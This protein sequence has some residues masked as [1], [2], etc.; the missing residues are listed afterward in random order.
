MVFSSRW[1]C[2]YMCVGDLCPFSCYEFKIVF[3]Y[4][5]IFFV[6]NT[7][8][9]WAISGTLREVTRGSFIILKER[10]MKKRWEDLSLFNNHLSSQLWIILSYKIEDCPLKVLAESKDFSPYPSVYHKK[11]HSKSTKLKISGF[12]CT[13]KVSKRFLLRS[14]LKCT[15]QIWTWNSTIYY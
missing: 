12:H 14:H 15:K 6:F 10:N 1:E 11:L 8:L 13:A 4:C 3:K 7:C 9:L 2:A 5:C